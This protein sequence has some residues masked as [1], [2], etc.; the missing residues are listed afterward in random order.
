MLCAHLKSDASRKYALV[1]RIFGSIKVEGF[2]I[3]LDRDYEV[4]G[5]QLG[6]KIGVSQ[7]VIAI[8]KNG[9]VYKYATGRTLK[10][11]DLDNPNVMRYFMITYTKTNKNIILFKC[12]FIEYL[13]IY[14]NYLRL[15]ARAS[16]RF[17]NADLASIPVYTTSG[18]LKHLEKKQSLAWDIEKLVEVM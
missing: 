2:E 13:I 1:L 9:V 7:P 8:F 14:I 18:E 11:D 5:L 4:M 3:Q 10:P 16:A 12:A 17:N 6:H 15:L